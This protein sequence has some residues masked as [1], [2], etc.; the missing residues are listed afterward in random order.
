MYGKLLFMEELLSIGGGG[1]SKWVQN[2]K[3]DRFLCVEQ[4]VLRVGDEIEKA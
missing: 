2:F 1:V 4:K 3:S